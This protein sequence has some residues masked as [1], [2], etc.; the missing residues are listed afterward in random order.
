M[1]MEE[2]GPCGVELVL[3]RLSSPVKSVANAFFPCPLG[4]TSKYVCFMLCSQCGAMEV[5]L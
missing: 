2:G 1:R 4:Q 3:W 5:F